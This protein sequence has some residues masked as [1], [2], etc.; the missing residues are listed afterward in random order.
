MKLSRKQTPT[1]GRLFFAYTKRRKV[2]DL[3]GVDVVALGELL[4]DFTPIGLSE[5]GAMLYARNAGGAPANV[6]S[7]LSILGKSTAFIGKVGQDSFGQFLK[8]TLIN[9]GILVE[10]LIESAYEP[11]TLAFVQLDEYGNRSFD[12]FRKHSADI[13]LKKEEILLHLLK[14]CQ[15]FHFGSVSMTAQPAR[16]ATLFAAH[17]ARTLGK[18]VSYDPNYRP[19]LWESQSEA[20]QVM[21]AG[22]EY[23]DI[24]KVSDNEVELLTGEHDFQRGASSLIRNGAK[25]ALV[26]AGANGTW[27][28]SASGHC[29]HIPSYKVEVVDTTGAG[30]TFLGALLSQILDKNI[31][32]N[33]MSETDIEEAIRFSNVAGALSTTKLGAIPAMPAKKEIEDFLKKMV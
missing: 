23:A 2:G 28:A 11:T 26:T 17:E 27:Y 16:D 25:L 24:V 32:L 6:L 31:P 22:L 5:Q 30:D 15:I 8:R 13:M 14:D 33:N 19:A 9:N 20:I 7:M 10:N 12:F 3:S 21:R 18:L 29:G 4:I 1:I